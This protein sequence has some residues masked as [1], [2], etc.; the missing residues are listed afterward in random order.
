MRVPTGTLDQLEQAFEA[1]PPNQRDSWRLHRVE[2]GD[3]PTTLAKRYGTTPEMIASVNRGEL[4][5]PGMFAAIPVPYPGDRV[6]VKRTV[7]PG[8]APSSVAAALK[9]GAKPNLLTSAKPSPSTGAKPSPL[10]G[11]KQSPPP[12]A[13]TPT[14]PAAPQLVAVKSPTKKPVVAQAPAQ[15]PHKVVNPASARKPAA[16]PHTPGA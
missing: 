3:T 5:E 6:P 1:I 12:S 8:P 13:K 2:S 7:K 9:T 16:A 15:A 11:V 4:P 10:T 14:K